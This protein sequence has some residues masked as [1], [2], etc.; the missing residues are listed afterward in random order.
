VLKPG[1]MN[2]VNKLRAKKRRRFSARIKIQAAWRMGLA[3][4]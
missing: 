1:L 2:V 3:R 4:R